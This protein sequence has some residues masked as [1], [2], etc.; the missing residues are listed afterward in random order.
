MC[1]LGKYRKWCTIQVGII[2]HLS[3]SCVFKKETSLEK[4]ASLSLCNYGVFTEWIL[5]DVLAVDSFPRLNS[6]FQTFVS[7]FDDDDYT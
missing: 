1:V 2:L 5:S 6:H 7:C 4:N 3:E